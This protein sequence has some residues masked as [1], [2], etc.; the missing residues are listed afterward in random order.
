MTDQLTVGILGCGEITDKRRADQFVAAANVRIGMA[1]DVDETVAQDIGDRFDVPFTTKQHDLLSRDDIDFVYI[2]T[3]HHLHAEQAIAVA[4]AG[5]HVLV[6]KP[7]TIDLDSATEVIETC[8]RRGVTLSVCETY[9]YHA[10]YRKARELIDARYL[11][12]IVGTKINIWAR[13]PDSYWEGGYTGRI[14]TDWRKSRETSGGGV[15]STNAVHNI[16]GMRYLTGLDAER[17][18]CE[19]D[20][21]ATPVDVEDF[22]VVTV[23]YGNGAIGLIETS[24]FLQDAPIEE[25]VRADRVYGT[26]GELVVGDPL[27]IRTNAE[28]DLGDGETWHEISP[29]DLRSAGVRFIEDFANS[30]LT[31]TEPPVT[32]EDGRK[33]LELVAA[34]YTAGNEGETVTLPLGTD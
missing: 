34:A 14:E 2:A 33:A 29:D 3:P 20:T 7:I 21:F 1:M 10:E 28:T 6:E 4:K 9:R 23:R 25:S 16:D 27:R 8:R 17:V 19:Y 18:A 11:G 24:S 22:C 15:L 12:D 5:K 30:V 13:K 26:E 31:D 32:G